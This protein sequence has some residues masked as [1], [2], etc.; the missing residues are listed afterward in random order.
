M[1][2][3]KN[4]AQIYK[5]LDHPRETLQR[6]H[7]FWLLRGARRR[8]VR[9]RAAGKQL[10]CHRG[11]QLGL[12]HGRGNGRGTRMSRFST[13]LRGILDLGV[14]VALKEGSAYI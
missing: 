4:R 6:V 8:R 14:C 11:L 1:N 7:H 10:G 12:C 13:A 3:L 5:V 9:D 2:R